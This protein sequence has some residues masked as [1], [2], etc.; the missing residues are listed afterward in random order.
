VVCTEPGIEYIINFIPFCFV[1]PFVE[2]ITYESELKA[3][4]LSQI[5]LEQFNGFWDVVF[6]PKNF[7][8]DPACTC[9][10]QEF[11]LNEPMSLLDSNLYCRV[12][13]GA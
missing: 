12:S 13:G 9:V 4:N 5:D 7:W 1:N 6:Y 11:N 10:V 2:P 3:Q 8:L